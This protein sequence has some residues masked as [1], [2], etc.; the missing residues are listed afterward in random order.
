MFV[1]IET[2]RPLGRVK[3]E[4][5]LFCDRIGEDFIFVLAPRREWNGE[6]CKNKNNAVTVSHT[7]FIY[8]LQE[9]C[10]YF[11]LNESVIRV[12][13]KSCKQL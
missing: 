13:L 5:T 6:R 4:I 10:G 1:M 9:K 7:K 2:D 3:N 11:V 12:C 8:L